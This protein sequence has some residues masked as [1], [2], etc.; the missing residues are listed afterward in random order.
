[1]TIH[2]VT[3]RRARQ[4]IA[5]VW[6]L[7]PFEG[8]VRDLGM[9]A[10]IAVI[11]GG[12]GGLAVAALAAR[13]GR[14]VVVLEKAPELGGRGRAQ[15]LGG[16]TFNLGPHALYRNGAAMRVLD[17]LGVPYSGGMPGAAGNLAWRGGR[18]HT[19]PSGP[20]S[21]L[22]TDLISFGTKLELARFLAGVQ[23]ERPE[24]LEGTSV[25]DFAA[26]RF[27]R[28]GSL[29]LF[30]ALVRVTSYCNAPERFSAGSAVRQLQHALRHNVLYLNGGW[31]TLVEGLRA[32]AEGA[33]AR[34]LCD[35]R[36]AGLEGKT[37]VL[38][39]GQRVEAGAVVV[40]AG[41]PEHAAE[42]L[43]SEA[44]ASHARKALPIRAACL[45]LAMSSLPEPRRTFALGI[46]VPLYASVHTR[47]AELGPPGLVVMQVAR[48]LAPG[49]VGSEALP[50]LEALMDALQPGWRERVVGRRFLPELTV[51]HD[52]PEASRGGAA[53]R[54]P[55][56]VPDAPGA[57][58]VGDWVGEEGLLADTVLASAERTVALLLERPSLRAAA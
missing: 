14:S 22:S 44:L 45:D 19:L 50:G 51:I 5:L 28:R 6:T 23:R 53:G 11:G 29:E 42:L 16:G 10:D 30:G 3:L 58:V 57:Y 1:L 27:S 43:R 48:Y 38:A 8:L 17:R 37:V 7:S 12:L 34:V 24:R 4:V 56:V 21:L 9:N 35:A 52:A 33:G 2:H 39:D 25:A 13:G 26:K 49:E 31:S 55:V 46:D 36:V 41:G 47:C 40:A 15:T 32:A 20:V 18:L 54:F